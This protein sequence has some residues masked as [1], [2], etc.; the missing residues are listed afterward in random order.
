M[1]RAIEAVIFDL[2][3][4]LIEYAGPYQTWPEL[5][6]PGLDVAYQFLQQGGVDMPSFQLF[7]DTAFAILPDR[8]HEATEGL[9]NLRLIDYL[10]EVLEALQITNVPADWLATAAHLYQSTICSRGDLISGARETVRLLKKEGY[11][12][13][14]LSNTMFTGESHIADLQRFGL[15]PYF[16]AMLFSADTNMWKPAAAPYLHLLQQLQVPAKRAVFICDS[17]HHD[18]AGG[19][20]AGMATIYFRSSSRL[21]DPDGLPPDA[22]IHDLRELPDLLDGWSGKL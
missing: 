13:G 21:G 12:L 18:I 16:D 19:Q 17:P 15:E 9:R 1:K 10:A 5:E 14:L 6:T 11:R 3:G 4:T 8:W 2:G 20:E 7:R 22:V